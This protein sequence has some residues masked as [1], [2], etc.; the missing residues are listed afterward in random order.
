ML[1]DRPI[2]EHAVADTGDVTDYC[3]HDLPPGDCG[4][5]RPHRRQRPHADAYTWSRFGPDA[6]LISPDH[7]AHIPG[8]GTHHDEHVVLTNGWGWIEHPDPGQ[9]LRIGNG[10]SLRASSGNLNRVADKRCKD[11][12]PFK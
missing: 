9:W 1:A 6:I 8:A 2:S 4:N 11:C 10:T 3:K 7:Y 5:C 12:E